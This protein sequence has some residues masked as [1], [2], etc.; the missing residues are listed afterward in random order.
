MSL[1]ILGGLLY[2]QSAL[3]T[4]LYKVLVF[5]KTTD[6][7]LRHA[8]IPSA[9]SAIQSLGAANNFEVD[10]TED[11]SVFNSLSGLS[12]Y[13]AVI[14]ALTYGDVLN[15]AQQSVMQSYI[16]SGKGFVGVHSASATE[17]GWSWYQGLVGATYASRPATQGDV[18]ATVKVADPVHPST[19]SLPR[20]WVRADEWY[21]FS[22]NPRGK[23]H[24][25]ATV[26][27]STYGGGSMGFDHPIAWCLGY[28]GGRSWYTAG[29]HSS[30]SWIGTQSSNTFLAHV[31]GG[32]QY[33]A[34]G[35]AKRD[36][37]ATV[38]ANI[39]RVT[40]D[41]HVDQPMSLQVAA[42]GRVF[43]I[44]RTGDLK[45]YKP[46]SS[47]SGSTIQSG[48]INTSYTYDHGLQGLAL[49]PNFATNH[50][51][52]LFYTAPAVSSGAAEQE[53]LSRFYMNG[54]TLDLSSEQVMRVS[55][56]TGINGF[57]R[58]GIAPDC[59]HQGGSLAFGPDGLL[60]L[61]T[62]DDS[63]A[64]Q[65]EGFSP[66]DERSGLYH[67]DAQR[68]AGNTKDLRGK[69]LRIRPDA[70]TATYTIP[71]GNLFP[72][73]ADGLGEIYVMGL[74]NPF[75][76][77]IDQQKNWLYWG[78]VGPDAWYDNAQRGSR[79]YDEINQARQAGNFGWPY[80]IG[81]NQPYIDYDYA[82]GVSG[83][84]FNC[85]APVN[86]SP[87][88]T[89][90]VNLPPAQKALIW[91]PYLNSSTF[92]E[93][94]R[95]NNPQTTCRTAEAGPVYHYDPN[96][97]SSTK[98]PAYYDGSLFIYDWCRGWIKE[99]KLD[100]QGNLL[101]IN[102]F[103]NNQPFG[104]PIDM[105]MGPEGSLYVLDF[106]PQDGTGS[107]FG[108]ANAG[109][110]V[111][112][113]YALNGRT[114]VAKADQSTPQSGDAPLTVNF[115][116]AGSY[117]PDKE[118]VTSTVWDFGDGSPSSTAY[119]PTHTYARGTYTASLTVSDGSGK[120][121]TTRVTISSGNHAPQVSFVTPL[122]GQ[123]V[124]FNQPTSVQD[125]NQKTINNPTI[126]TATATQENIAYQVSVNDFEDGSSSDPAKTLDICSRVTV[127]VALGHGTHSHPMY[128]LTG[129]SGT[130]PTPDISHAGDS[131]LY[132]ILTASYVDTG[133]PSVLPITTASTVDAW[134]DRFQAEHYSNAYGMFAKL[135]SNDGYGGGDSL[136]GIGSRDWIMFRSVNLTGVHSLAYRVSTWYAGG[137]IQVHAGALDGPIISEAIIPYT[138]D[139]TIYAQI[140]APIADQ[141]GG[142]TNDLYFEFL[143]FKG[144]D[145][146]GVDTID[147]ISG[148]HGLFNLNWIDF[149]TARPPSVYPPFKPPGT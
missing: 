141:T 82:T 122:N 146:F 42:D 13:A 67:N 113:D 6:P 24:V 71:S 64:S 66:I 21:N 38:E 14:F 12:Q 53:T 74:R 3:A 31:L 73:S 96:L 91:Y 54:D 39:D 55:G 29:G 126:A 45:I 40:L 121:S 134:P 17:T 119:N 143:T 140:V 5:T 52:Y 109:Y 118:D 4:P 97:N 56:S 47:Y 20:R 114:P 111:R 83:P 8:S 127:H 137:R 60:Y 144:N 149:L 79:G 48:H 104:N 30:A 132:M 49:D 115:S 77:S 72:S 120:A 125:V 88:N 46:T 102:P 99:V 68:S 75:R 133:A 9:I 139:P 18:T 19:A 11:A 85:N 93:V 106:G 35:N 76:I 33:A 36:C 50:A 148:R 90:K 41:D 7:N 59:C 142:K 145:G 1:S 65:S 130:V 138:A 131:Q 87:M 86:N 26:D 110:L 103:L 28:Q 129:C 101:K 22:T 2:A 135:P 84:A 61:S 69:I 116:S 70:S 117:D 108:K 27:E 94:A 58:F 37:G 107:Y 80:C 32:I 136:M 147:D 124:R 62:G 95:N 63:S 89:G 25:L 105:E 81:D 23:V 112:I 98:L 78:E 44:Q 43:F 100:E 92:P 10:A 16:A 123:I 128:D 34:S 57:L 15:D 51:I